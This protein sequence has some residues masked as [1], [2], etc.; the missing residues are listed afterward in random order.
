[1]E[2]AVRIRFFQHRKNHAF[3][4]VFYGK[5][6]GVLF[7]RLRIKSYSFGFWVHLMNYVTKSQD[8]ILAQTDEIFPVRT[9]FFRKIERRTK[10]PPSC[11]KGK[12]PHTA[13]KISSKHIDRTKK[14]IVPTRK[15]T[16]AIF[17][18]CADTFIKNTMRKYR[19]TRIHLPPP[20]S[21]QPYNI[22][23][24]SISQKTSYCNEKITT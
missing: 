20:S 10:I 2:Y 13:S 24:F 8:C 9:D 22:R 7:A 23:Q 14:D 12:R 5:F 15:Q 16:H 6:S 3:R 4:H 19:G 11:R 18:S 1:M 21:G 17:S